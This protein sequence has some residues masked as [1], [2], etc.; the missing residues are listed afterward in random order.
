MIDNQCFPGLQYRYRYM[1]HNE[2]V[3]NLPAEPSLSSA[4]LK[5]SVIQNQNLYIKFVYDMICFIYCTKDQFVQHISL[6]LTI[7]MNLLTRN[8]FL[9]LIVLGKF[10]S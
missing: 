10:S 9:I 7:S 4:E 2:E 1:L 3:F 8:L 5:M 6:H